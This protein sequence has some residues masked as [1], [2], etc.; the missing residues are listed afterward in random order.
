MRPGRNGYANEWAA[1]P[2]Q[3]SL[4]MQPRPERDARLLADTLRVV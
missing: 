1:R 4:A 3:N 2:M